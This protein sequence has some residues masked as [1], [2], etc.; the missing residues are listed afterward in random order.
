MSVRNPLGRAEAQVAQLTYDLA[1]LRRE[2]D[3]AV[4]RLKTA[5]STIWRLKRR[6]A[7]LLA[8]QQKRSG[9]VSQI[10]SDAMWSREVSVL[11]EFL[12][13]LRP[14]GGAG[15]PAGALLPDA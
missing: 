6:N 12:R 14:L 2:F 10:S 7:V 11:L 1:D 5:T 15:R 3:R 9:V 4:S 13:I 8:A